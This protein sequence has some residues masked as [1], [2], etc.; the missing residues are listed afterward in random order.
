M[1]YVRKGNKN[2]VVIQIHERTNKQLYYTL[3]GMVAGII[4]GVILKI[5]ASPEI[6]SIFSETISGSVQKVF[7]NAL[8]MMI[9]PMVFF[10]IIHG[11]TSL[12]DS[13]S[14]GRIGGKLISL[15][16][17]TTIIA[18]F[19]GLTLAHFIFAGGVP[20]VG[21]VDGDIS[22]EKLSILS[23]II[24][25][26]PA[27]ILDPIINL[28]LM[29]VIFIAVIFG[30]CLNKLGDKV[31]SLNNFANEACDFTL[32]LVTSIA[33][34]IPLITFFA[35]ADMMISLGMD[36]VILLGRLLL[37]VVIGA[38]I[39]I[40]VY[41]SILMIFGKTSPLPLLK[42]LPSF[43]PIPFSTSSSNITMPF[44]MKFCTDKIGISPKISSFSI[45][46]GATVNMDGTAIIYAASCTMILRMYGIEIDSTAIFTLLLSIFTVS[47]GTPG[48]P[49]STV[50]LR[51]AI[52][53]MFGV[54][55]EAVA[56]VMGISTIEDRI[57][58]TT[59]VV[60]DIAVT[61]AIAANENLL[62]MNIY[63]QRN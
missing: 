52:L 7:M 41:S 20:Q 59:N 37:C 61:T 51:A 18:I 11:I 58:T 42:K 24:N 21:I 14:I 9:V 63:E 60:G 36:S 57:T 8:S 46:I 30:L 2:L 6:I 45:P 23:T 62:D 4:L 49:G 29:Q 26:V 28:N 31:K 25:I 13:A 32:S 35:M 22:K 54:P 55:A 19:V 47:V 15:Y 48:I 53:G 12:T 40:C 34:F 16:S 1:H 5:T 44:T 50:V 56:I 3:V 27:N 43:I 33:A 39:M 10:S 38:L 17:L